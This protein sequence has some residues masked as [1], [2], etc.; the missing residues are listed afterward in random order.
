MIYLLAFLG[1]Y[2]LCSIP[3]MFRY[4]KQA[5]K[6][7]DLKTENE[8]YSLQLHELSRLLSEEKDRADTAQKSLARVPPKPVD[9]TATKE[10]GALSVKYQ[11]ALN[12]INRLNSDLSYQQHLA[13]RSAREYCFPSSQWQP[14]HFPPLDLNEVYYAPKSGNLFHTVRWCYALDK[15]HEID[16]CSYRNAVNLR[17]L[18]PCVRCVDPDQL[19]PEVFP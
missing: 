10:Y 13:A 18:R 2:F 14:A 12:T 4:V 16:C 1:G 8:T 5:S 9:I 15:S 7:N 19:P 6:L 11:N 17:H 3:A